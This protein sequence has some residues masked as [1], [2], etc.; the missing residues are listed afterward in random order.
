M[1]WGTLKVSLNVRSFAACCV[2][3]AI[4]SG[5]LD[6]TRAA[7]T[8]Y[9]C[10]YNCPGRCPEDRSTHAERNLHCSCKKP[11]VLPSGYMADCTGDASAA[12]NGKSSRL[13]LKSAVAA[14]MTLQAQQCITDVIKHVYSQE[15]H[16][17]STFSCPPFSQY[18]SS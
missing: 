6:V 11:C 10:R 9:N 17:R 13:V 2:I 4:A 14:A 8:C 15:A 18:S 3:R 12:G 5:S 7:A 16:L 1:S